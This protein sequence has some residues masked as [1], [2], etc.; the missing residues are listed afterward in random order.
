MSQDVMCKL[1]MIFNSDGTY[2]G[3]F[4]EDMPVEK[5]RHQ[6]T[7]ALLLEGFLHSQATPC[8]SL[9]ASQVSITSTVEEE[10]DKIWT[11]M[12]GIRRKYEENMKKI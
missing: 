6:H 1:L 12:T 11:G 3:Y 9:Q 7:I 8:P 5:L 4:W 2:Y 10:N